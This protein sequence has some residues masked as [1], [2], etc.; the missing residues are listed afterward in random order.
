MSVNSHSPEHHIELA[1]FFN[2][3]HYSAFVSGFGENSVFGKKIKLI[4]DLAVK[5]SVHTAAEG[6]RIVAVNICMRVLKILV[7]IDKAAIF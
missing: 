3:F 1:V 4:V 6:K 2:H 7:H 5:N